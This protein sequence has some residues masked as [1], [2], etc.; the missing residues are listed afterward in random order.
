MHINISTYSVVY[1]S[2]AADDD[3]SQYCENEEDKGESDIDAAAYREASAETAFGW[4]GIQHLDLDYVYSFGHVYTELVN[5]LAR[6]PARIIIR[7][8]RFT[9]ASGARD[10]NL[11]R[12][13]GRI[14]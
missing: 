11:R 14:V 4:R 12:A 6:I 1:C 7:P 8:L 10:H 5:K 2:E 3:K 13:S 9:H